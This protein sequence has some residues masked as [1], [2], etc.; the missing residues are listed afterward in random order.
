MADNQNSV[1]NLIGGLEFKDSKLAS[2]IQTIANDLYG[3]QRQVNPPKVQSSNL[4]PGG[5]SIVVGPPTDLVITVFPNDI[6]L[7]WS[8]APSGIFLYEIRL[9]NDFATA[10]I[11]LTTAT[12]SAD[13]DPVSRF[14]ITN[15]TY[16]FWVTAID[17]FGNRSA[18]TFASVTIPSIG[19]PVVTLTNIGNNILLRWTIPS[20][21]FTIDHYIVSKNG[22]PIGNIGGTFDVT[23][24]GIAGTYSYTVQAVDIV[25]NIGPPSG[26]VTVTLDNPS[27]YVLLDS[28][29]SI[30]A[31]TKVESVVDHGKLFTVVT[32]DSWQNHFTS[33]FWT[34]IQDQLNAGYP[35]YFEPGPLSTGYY[36]EVF[37]FGLVIDNVI[38]N[39]SYNVTNV[40]GVVAVAITIATSTDGITYNSPSVGPSLYSTSMRYAKVRLTFTPADKLSAI[41]I[42]NFVCSLSVKYDTDQGS[43]ILNASD[44]TGTVVSFNKVFKFVVSITLGSQ[45]L[46]PID[47]IYNF[48]FPTN[49]T[50]FKA[51]A[52]D[53]TGNRINILATWQ[54]RGLT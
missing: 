45:S 11:L 38:V 19:T 23:F 48:S 17:D 39:T 5:A 33:N 10:D 26:A 37:D 51:L 14:I 30:F 28:I 31:G 27:D 32:V 36:E 52:F 40:S 13:I 21:A 50:S 22:S 34:S 54:A 44:A 42:S 1:N 3:L 41:E 9:G 15:T 6:R 16:T 8:P 24:E 35:L 53:N 47:L 18:A 46:Q 43:V 49:P 2:L 25:G 20:S 12:F 29:T 4:N 7:N